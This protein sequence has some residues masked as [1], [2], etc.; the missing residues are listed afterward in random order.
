M[1]IKYLEFK[2]GFVSIPDPYKNG[3]TCYTYQMIDLN[4]MRQLVEDA[5]FLYIIGNII[6]FKGAMAE[7]EQ[8]SVADLV[9]YENMDYTISAND[10]VNK[11]KELP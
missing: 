5:N 2:D 7:V 4:I 11:D 1:E 9:G 6:Y 10:Y 8:R 3:R